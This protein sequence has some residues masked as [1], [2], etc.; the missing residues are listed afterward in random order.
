MAVTRKA[1]S[2]H[3]TTSMSVVTVGIVDSFCCCWPAARV[4]KTSTVNTMT[5]GCTHLSLSVTPL[6]MRSTL[7]TPQTTAVR[8]NDSS[9]AEGMARYGR[10]W[11]RRFATRSVNTSFRHAFQR[12]HRRSDSAQREVM[13][14]T[15]QAVR[16]R[17]QKT[18]DA[19]DSKALLRVPCC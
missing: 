4:E 1:S 16:S 3:R 7:Y 12:R 14:E 5:C 15:A 11:L 9:Q 18:G 8:Q 10:V 19:G 6:D 13:P 17:E 2:Q